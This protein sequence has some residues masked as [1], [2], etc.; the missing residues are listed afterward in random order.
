MSVRC[1]TDA[2][3]AANNERGVRVDSVYVGSNRHLRAFCDFVATNSLRS[4]IDRV[5]PFEQAR[6]ALEFPEVGQHFGKVAIRI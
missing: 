1:R 4:V 3:T 6:E 5:F 2:K